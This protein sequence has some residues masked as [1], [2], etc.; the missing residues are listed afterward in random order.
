MRL[1]MRMLDAMNTALA[2]LLAGEGPQGNYT[3]DEGK[4][5]MLEGHKAQEWVWNEIRK[6]NDRKN[7]R[8]KGAQ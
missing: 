2:E 1:T 3:E 7:G 8:P 4:A 6:R 5:L